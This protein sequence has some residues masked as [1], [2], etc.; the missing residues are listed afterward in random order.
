MNSPETH[1]AVQGAREISCD[2][3]GTVFA[4]RRAWTR[5]CGSACRNAFHASE[6]RL[7][8]IRAAGPRLYQAL[9]GLATVE[10]PV[11]EIARGAIAGLKPPVEPKALLEKSKA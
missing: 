10:G 4:V 3:C 2:T 9:A 6:R 7:E 8:A 11:G 1:F 5:F